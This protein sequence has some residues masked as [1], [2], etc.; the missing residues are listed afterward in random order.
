MGT[1]KMSSYSDRSY[2]R[3]DL[4]HCFIQK[5]SICLTW[6][7]TDLSLWP[8]FILD[9][10]FF[11]F[12]KKRFL[13][14]SVQYTQVNL[15]IDVPSRGPPLIPQQIIKGHEVFWIY[16]N[17]YHSKSKKSCLWSVVTWRMS[18]GIIV[19]RSSSIV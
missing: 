7:R 13:Y 8:L 5:S 12:A 9:L 19:T 15:Q 11:P 2:F 6:A 4:K 10:I 17:Q 18:D 14:V 1:F 16:Q 3:K